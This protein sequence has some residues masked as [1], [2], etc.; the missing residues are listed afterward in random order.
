MLES[1]TKAV[2]NANLVEKPLSKESQAHGITE[3][4]KPSLRVATEQDTEII[5]SW[6]KNEC[7]LLWLGGVVELPVKQ[8]VKNWI[9]TSLGGFLLEC[10]PSG[11]EIGLRDP[12]A[13]ATVAYFG[14]NTNKEAVEVGRLIVDPRRRHLGFGSTLLRHLSSAV[15]LAQHPSERAPTAVHIRTFSD[16][17][18]AIAM[19]NGLPFDE[20]EA[21]QWA[22]EIDVER[23]RWFSYRLLMWPSFLG[24]EMRSFRKKRNLSQA[25][26]AFQCGVTRATINMIESGRRHPSLDLLQTLT[27]ILGNRQFERVRLLLAAIGESPETGLRTYEP[28]QQQESSIN[29]NLWIISDQLAEAIDSRFLD[30][31]KTAIHRGFDRWYFVPA[32]QWSEKRVK[33]LVNLFKDSYIEDAALIR[34]LRFYEAPSFLCNLRI[35]IKNPGSLYADSVTVEGEGTGRVLL[36]QNRGSAL[37]LSILEIVTALEEFAKRGE[38]R[39]IDGF[40]RLFPKVKSDEKSRPGRVRT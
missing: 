21:P 20:H 3:W 33:F 19:I 22:S 12:V 1:V 2:L 4:P 35:E 38:S 16:N 34:H 39:S 6:V 7:E 31:S 30:A 24:E 36:G 9:T 37:L 13:F 23:C 27:R 8:Q 15:Q 5:A 28:L 40:C 25:T 17:N 10:T 32:G 11:K 14:D 29:S 18:I 26:L